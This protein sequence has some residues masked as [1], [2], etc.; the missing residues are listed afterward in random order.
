VG[1]SAYFENYLK[2]DETNALF[3]TI[4]ELFTIDLDQLNNITFKRAVSRFIYS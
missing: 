2:V 1:A 4:I 3:N